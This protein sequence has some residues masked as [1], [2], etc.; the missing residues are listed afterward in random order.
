[1]A[2][3]S[4]VILASATIILTTLAGCAGGP[5]ASQGIAV[6]PANAAIPLLN[7]VQ[8]ILNASLAN[9]A[10]PM[11]FTQSIVDAA[12]T[13]GSDLYEPTMEVSENGIIYVTGHTIG[14]DTTGAPVFMSKDN[15]KSWSQLPFFQ[16]LTMPADLPGAT[17]PVSDEIFLVAG[18][19]GWL[20]GVDITLATFP[21]NGWSNDGAQH[22]Y[23]NPNAYDEQQ[24]ALQ[25]GNCI[26]AP[27]KDRPWAAYADDTLL[28]V[29]NPASGPAQIGVL[30]V[31]PT[32]AIPA[33]PPLPVGAGAVSGGGWWNL[34][35]GTG[36]RPADCQIPGVPDMHRDGTF[37]V[38]QRC[39][40]SLYLITGNKANVMAT[41][42]QEMF[43]LTSGMEI[44][45]LYGHAAFD[46]EGTL[47]V[48]ITNNTSPNKDG[49]RTGQIRFAA[50]QDRG[51]TFEHQT[52]VT[53]LGAPVRHLYI[54][55]NKFGP[56][57]LVVWALNGTTVNAQ[58]VTTAFDWYAG[59][60]QIDDNGTPVL[61]NAFLIIDEG[62]M[63]SAHV[64]GAA[65]GPDGRGYT[66][67]FQSAARGGTPISVWIQESGPTL[68]ATN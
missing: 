30:P 6:D 20:W 64:T 16:T 54:D 59:H 24:V 3:A 4:L 42:I 58:N 34:C 21:V 61:E 8:S 46:Q 19:N 11:V 62:P 49:N 39:D 23:F 14:V 33:Q 63:P 31:P 44:T 7:D 60:L 26:A 68:P 29:S 51:Q 36:F 56:G 15:G 50:S 12:I 1:M 22:S 41:Q 32:Q 27:A 67:T 38:P 66:A 18:D 25:A 35:A 9:V 47:F 45:S 53:G 48:G 2:K 13:Y 5:K 52:Y 37:A 57:A 55:S 28:M 65:V 17:P 40:G 10:G 43:P